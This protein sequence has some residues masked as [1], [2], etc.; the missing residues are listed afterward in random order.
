M[1]GLQRRPTPALELSE[2]AVATTMALA[3]QQVTAA[4]TVRL[5]AAKTVRL[6]PYFM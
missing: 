1:N 5:S 4:T 2:V 6:G 3:I